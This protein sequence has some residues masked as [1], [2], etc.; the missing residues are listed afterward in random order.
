[1]KQV[2]IQ[3]IEPV[4]LNSRVA[5]D[6][7]QVSPAWLEDRRNSGDLPYCKIGKYIFMK[8]ADL[9]KMIERCRVY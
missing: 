9:D 6:Y 8:K 3:K 4:Y 1:M 2:D 5:A 7:L